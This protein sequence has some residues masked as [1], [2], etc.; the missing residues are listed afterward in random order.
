MINKRTGILHRPSINTQSSPILNS[1]TPP[2]I[3]TIVST[4]LDQGLDLAFTASERAIKDWGRSASEITH[5][6]CTTCT[7]SSHPGYDLYLHQRLDLLPSV[8]RTLI[9]GIGCAGGLS[10]IRLARNICIAAKAQGRK[11]RV[12]VV[13]LEITTSLLRTELEGLDEEEGG[14]PNVASTIFSDAASAMI[15]GSDGLM[16]NG[17]S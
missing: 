6:I 11:A 12:L 4:F 2:P 7:A 8:E 9:H 14:K 13:A 15:V 5:L 10:I 16:E 17:E 1:P 3:Q